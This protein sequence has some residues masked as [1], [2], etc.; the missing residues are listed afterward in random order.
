MI[1]QGL[2][3]ILRIIFTKRLRSCYYRYFRGIAADAFKNN[4]EQAIEDYK[5]VLENGGMVDQE[6]LVYTVMGRAYAYNDDLDNAEAALLKALTLSIKAKGHNPEL[7]QWLAYVN[8]KKGEF[9][10]AL[11]YFKKASKFGAKGIDKLIVNMKYVKEHENFLEKHKGYFPLFKMYRLAQSGKN[12]KNE[13][14]DE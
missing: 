2:C 1:F 7:Y 8:L 4:Y 13:N 10:E 5:Y 12:K 3:R 9:E 6:H 11:M 14:E